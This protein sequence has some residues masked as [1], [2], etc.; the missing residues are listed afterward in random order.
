MGKEVVTELVRWDNATI[1]YDNANTWNSAVCSLLLQAGASGINNNSGPLRRAEI[2]GRVRAVC[3]LG[4]SLANAQGHR[5]GQGCTTMTSFSCPCCPR[6]NSSMAAAKGAMDLHGIHCSSTPTGAA[7]AMV[8]N[9]SRFSRRGF[10]CQGEEMA[11]LQ[12]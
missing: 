7:I 3:V 12:G 5:G 10:C 11:Q 1:Q 9:A 8:N 6:R 4:T 2:M